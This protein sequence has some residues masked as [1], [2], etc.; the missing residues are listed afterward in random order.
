[1]LYMHY[2]YYTFF[3]KDSGKFDRETIIWNRIDRIETAVIKLIF[4]L[5]LNLLLR[6]N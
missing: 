6:I 1:M 2:T 5:V 3:D 4:F